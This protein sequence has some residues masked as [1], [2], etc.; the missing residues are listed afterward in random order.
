MTFIGYNPSVINFLGH[1]FK[2]QNL[3]YSRRV[4]IETFILQVL[5]AKSPFQ[6]VIKD[7]AGAAQKN[8]A[9]RNRLIHRLKKIS[10][11]FQEKL[12]KMAEEMERQ[13]RMLNPT[14]PKEVQRIKN[15][16]IPP[17]NT[18]SGMFKKNS[19]LMK[20]TGGGGVA[21]VKDSNQVVYHSTHSRN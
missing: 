3:I 13:Q 14:V 19:L 6:E 16:L 15:Q 7:T 21:V 1:P 18:A 20:Q 4:L 12:D 11:E 17:E 8:D 2:R 5:S 10:D 9:F